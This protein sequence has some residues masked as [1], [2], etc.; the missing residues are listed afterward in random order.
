MRLHWYAGD[1]AFARDLVNA[2]DAGI[3]QLRLSTGVT[4][5][6]P[7]E[8]RIYQTPEA[9]R[10]TI[11]YSQEWAGGVAYANQGLV[12][13]GID[14]SNLDWG[15]DAMVH[16]MTH[17]VLGQAT[18]RCGSSLPA[19][20]NE[21][22]AVYNEDP[23]APLE[24][25][26]ALQFAILNNAAYSLRSIAGAFPAGRDG[27]VLAY[28]QSRSI[29]DFLIR[30]H[31]ADKMNELLTTFKALGT[32][33]RAL[34]EVYGFDT[35]GLDAAW[36]A[37]VGLPPRSTSGGI[38]EQPLPTIPPLGLPPQSQASATPVPPE[39]VTITATPSPTGAATITPTPTPALNGG[40]GCNRNGASAGLDGGLMLML[41]F[42][43]FLAVRRRS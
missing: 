1:E 5:S 20:L 11:L 38:E 31:G 25:Q 19:W 6:D 8:V 41:A 7:V 34:T 35:N 24:F 12:A 13:M 22:L 42:G 26:V 3:R 28:A 30:E 4:P 21:G 18:F 16:E 33:D 10:E 29:V 2:G 23:T 27:A 37:H 43:G 36:R 39:D 40:T 32:I 15:R 17:V 14:E 9:M